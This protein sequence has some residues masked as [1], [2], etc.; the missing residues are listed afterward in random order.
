LSTSARETWSS[1]DSQRP[2]VQVLWRAPKPSRPPSPRRVPAIGRVSKEPRR[3]VGAIAIVEQSDCQGELSTRPIVDTSHPSVN[4]APS[5]GKPQATLSQLLCDRSLGRLLSRL[6]AGAILL[7]DRGYDG[8][9]IR[10]LVRRTVR[11]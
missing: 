7:A 11:G 10:T 2:D 6:K 5:H 3:T 8:D 1:R 9:W 4:P